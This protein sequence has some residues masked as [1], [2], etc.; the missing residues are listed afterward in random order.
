[1]I[2]LDRSK[3][4]VIRW[5]CGLSGKAERKMHSFVDGW[6]QNQS[7]W[8]LGKADSNGLDTKNVKMILI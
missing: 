7:F 4:N 2:K 6:D 8:K 5:M 3:M 1:V